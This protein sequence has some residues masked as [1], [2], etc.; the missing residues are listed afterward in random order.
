MDERTEKPRAS[1]P[2]LR[3]ACAADVPRRLGPWLL[4]R[5][6]GQGPMATVYLARSAAAGANSGQYAV[7]VLSAAAQDDAFCVALFRREA[8]I[9]RR[10]AHANLMPVLSAE[11]DRPPYYWVAPYLRGRTVAQRLAGEE[12]F[13]V[14]HALWITR[15]IAEGLA[16]LHAAGYLHGDVKPANILVAANG[17]ATLID[18]GFAREINES[19][20]AS[21]EAKRRDNLDRPIA[22][23]LAYLPP[24]LLSSTTRS[25]ER[26]DL[27][28]LGAT[29]YEM[30]TSRQPYQV[31]SLEELAEKQHRDELP[32]IRALAPQIAPDAALLVRRLLARNPLRRPSS[33]H[34]VIARLIALEVATLPERIPA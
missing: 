1:A 33:A 34:E 8:T 5:V 14:P 19:G 10:I 27:Y 30:L 20:S 2:L 3:D 29:L 7:K 17:H 23:T 11:L 21:S 9:A 24:E 6:L 28:S 31:S 13:S 22:G 4:A 12:I 18:F 25:D 26:S 15:Q 16:A 32:D